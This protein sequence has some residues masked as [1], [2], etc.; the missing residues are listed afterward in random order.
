MSCEV[1][2][3]ICAVCGSFGVVSTIWLSLPE[4]SDKVC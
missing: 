2:R 4:L 1:K 3:L